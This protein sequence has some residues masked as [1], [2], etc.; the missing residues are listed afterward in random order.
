MNRN[1]P[2]LFIIL[3]LTGCDFYT[4]AKLSSE[5]N[6]IRN[7]CSGKSTNS[8]ETRKI[9]FNIAILSNTRDQL[10]ENG[11]EIVGLKNDE[12]EDAW[13]NF[14][15]GVID[16]YIAD[17]EDAKPG[18]F[19]RWVL[20]AF[21]PSS[22]KRTLLMNAQD[23]QSMRNNM[24][25]AYNQKL[26]PSV[27]K[28]REEN[29]ALLAKQSQERQI[30]RRECNQDDYE[31]GYLPCISANDFSRALEQQNELPKDWYID[32]AGTPRGPARSIYADS[33]QENI[34]GFAE[35]S[36]AAQQLSRAK[37]IK[38]IEHRFN[39]FVIGK[40]VDNFADIVKG[41]VSRIE[42]EV[43]RSEQSKYPGKTFALAIYNSDF[44]Q[45][46]HGDKKL[47]LGDL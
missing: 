44:C 4:D 25:S 42:Q 10:I 6:S 1:L 47:A 26:R 38:N 12:E 32:D 45:E 2:L 46:L 28:W 34:R 22:D 8:C 20:F 37:S 36:F 40:K 18:I 7:D 17:L 13:E 27:K 11:D 5:L 3:F 21:S 14:V 16:P 23:A 24:I 19:S 15:N 39:G 35:C 43:D 30:A 41:H 9:D 29:K 33:T 31:Y